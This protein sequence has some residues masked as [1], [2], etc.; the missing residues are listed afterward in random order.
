MVLTSKNRMNIYEMSKS[1]IEEE[2]VFKEI[3]DK[4][5][6]RMI[7]DNSVIIRNGWFM[8]GSGKRKNKRIY[9]YKLEYVI[10]GKGEREVVNER[11][12]VRKLSIRNKKEENEVKNV[13]EINIMDMII[14]NNNKK[15]DKKEIEYKE[16]RREEGEEEE[17]GEGRRRIDYNDEREVARRLT[18]MLSKERATGYNEWITVG[19]ALY[20]ISEE[21]MDEFLEFSKLCK[22]KYDE[23][24][25]K[26]VWRDTFNYHKMKKEKVGYKIASLHRWAREDNKE[27]YRRFIEGSINNIMRDMDFRAEFD[28]ALIIREMYKYDY[29]RCRISGS[30]SDS[31][32]PLLLSFLYLLDEAVEVS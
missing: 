32:I 14:K 10:N 1:K 26:R 19:W 3:E 24:Y 2:G 11:E 21:L 7:L 22:E 9:P 13:K 18:R 4:M 28:I 17:K 20:N 25:C 30:A 5:V 16:E 12:L 6:D 31:E 29:E 8:Y 27:E 23:S 15:E